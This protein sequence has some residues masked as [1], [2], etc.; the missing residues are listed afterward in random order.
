MITKANP[1]RVL[2]STVGLLSTATIAIPFLLPVEPASANC[3]VSSTALEVA[4]LTNQVRAQYRLRPLRFNCRLYGAAQ[5]HTIDMVNMNRL[6]HTGSDGSSIA[7]RVQRFGYQY[8]AVAENVAVGQ[9]TPSQVLTSW[10]ESPGHR[11]NIL[12]PKYTE[13][14]V[15]YSNNYWT[16]VFGRPR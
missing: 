16:Q 12:N 9:R 7:I 3:R 4:K 6:T 10:M 2:M 8:S 13:I 5:N 1:Q 11:Q 15:G 14:G